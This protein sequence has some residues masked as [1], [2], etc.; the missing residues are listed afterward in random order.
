[1]ILIRNTFDRPTIKS[2]QDQMNKKMEDKKRQHQND[3]WGL[4]INSIDIF[5]FCV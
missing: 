1:M 3:G 5:V 2:Q 4:F